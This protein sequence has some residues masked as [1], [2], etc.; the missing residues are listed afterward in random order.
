MSEEIPIANEVVASEAGSSM[1]PGS[2]STVH[3]HVGAVGK[4]N[5]ADFQNSV[6]ALRELAVVNGTENGLSDLTLSISSEP[7]FVRTRAWMLDAV[8]SGD[9]YHL[10]DLD[11]QIDGALLSRL[12]EAECATLKFD[13]RSRRAP[14]VRIAEYQL[15]VE[16][17][18]RNQWGGIGQLPEMIAAFVQPN[19]PAV[20]RLLRSAAQALQQAGLDSAITG[21]GAGPKH[22]WELGSG[23]WTALQQRRLSY[24]LPPAS[25]EATGQKIRGASQVLDA[26]IATCLDLTLIFAACLEQAHL[27]PLLIFTRG[28]AFVGYWL[29]EE[30]FS[31]PVVDDI[32]ALR[33]RLKL[34]E[35]VVFE[36]TLVTQDRPVPFSQAID[37]GARRLSEVDQDQFELA[38]DLKRARMSRIKPLAQA[39]ATSAPDLGAEEPVAIAAGPE[40]APELPEDLTDSFP[41]PPIEPKDRLTQ[42][43][44][45]LLDLSLRNALLN[46]KASKRS[47]QLDAA[48]PALEDALADGQTIKLLTSPFLMEGNDPRSQQLHEARSLED[49]RREHASDALERREVFIRLE[50]EELEGRLV[51]LYRAARTALQEGGANTLF[52]AL[53]FLTWVRPDRPDM[54]VKA[55]LILLPVT[56]ERKSARSGFTI[57]AHEDE[58]RFNPTLVEMLNQDFELDLGIPLGDLPRDESGLDV[59]GIWKRVRLAIKDVNGWEINEDVVLSM[60]SFAK[61]LM[62][63]DLVDR[64]ADLRQ[65]PVVRHLIDTPRE[66][67]RS[68][69]DFPEARSLDSDYPPQQVFSPL[70]ADSSQLS[71]VMAASKGK[72]FVLIGPPGTGKSQTI[73]NLIAQCLAENKRVLFVAEK[74]AALDVVHRRLREVG[75]SEFCLE[76][77]SSKTRKLD[78]LRQLHDAWESTGNI[79][80]ESWVAKADQLR[81]VRDQLSSYV[82]RLHARHT[83]GLTIF[84][85]IGTVVSG[86]SLPELDLSW[87]SSKAHDAQ[88]LGGMRE[89]AGRLSVNAS[90]VG[91]ANLASGPLSQI[92]A[93]DWSVR[94]Q[95]ELVRSA[96]S[97]RE[98]SQHLAESAN[99]LC[100]QLRMSWPPLNKASRMSLGIIAKSLPLAA[101]H[102]WSFFAL[103]QGAEHSA[104]LKAGTELLVDHRNLS[105]QMTAPW[106]LEVQ[107]RLQSA[108]SLLVSRRRI[109]ATLGS[110]LPVA[111]AELLDQG[112]KAL[113]E[114]NELLRGLSVKYGPGINGINVSLLLR[115]WVKA[116]RA[117]WPI[118]WIGR[119]KVRAQLDAVIEG[120][121]EPRIPDDLAALVRIKSL[122]IEL[123]QID[124]GASEVGYWNGAKTKVDNARSASKANIALHAVRSGKSFSLEGVGAASSGHCG[125]RWAAEVGRLGELRQHDQRIADASELSAVSDGLWRGAETDSEALE[126][127]MAFELERRGLLKSGAPTGDHASIAKGRCGV[128]LQQDLIRLQSRV[129]IEQRLRALSD[130][131]THCHDVWRGL[132]TD[133]DKVTQARRFH[134]LL[135]S[136]LSGLPSAIAIEVRQALR[137]TLRDRSRE[138]KNDAGIGRSCGQLVSRLSELNSAVEAFSTLAV[139]PEDCRRATADLSPM[140]LVN[141]AEQVHAH[142]QELHAW[143]GWRSAEA[144]ANAVGLEKLTKSLVDGR[145]APADCARAFEVGYARWW[146][147]ETVDEDEVIKRFV[148][149]E[150]ERR[151]DTFRALD[152]EFTK[153]TRQW[154]RAKLCADLPG[155]DSPLRSAEWGALRREITKKRMHKPLRQLLQEIPSV[156][157]RLTPCLLMSPL[158]IAQ[159]LSASANNFDLVVFDEASQI[160]V[161]DAI[162]AMA[163]GKQVVMVGDPKQLPPTNFFDRAESS[164][165][166]AADVEGDLESILDECIGASLPMRNLSWHYRSKHESLIAFSN[167]RYYGGSLVTFPSP[168]TEDRA[169]SF[170]FVDG[171][172]EKGGARIN[173]PE[174]RA[175]VKDLVGRLKQ[176]KFRESRLTIGVVTFN[177]EQ[178]R[179]IEDLLDEERRRDPSLESYFSEEELEPVFVKNL[180]S[181]QGD[182]RDIMYFSITYGPD[183]TG[184]IAMNFGPLNRDG[185]ERRLNVA[186]TRARHEL[187]VFSSIRGDQIDL[188]RTKAAGVLDLKH[189]LEFAERGS[190]A[191]AEANLGSR[192]DIES[193]FEG[194]VAAA[195]A[196]KGWR[197]DTQIGSSSFRVDLGVVHPDLPGRYLAGIECDG[198]TYHRSATARDRD[199]LREQ[200]L[201][202]LGWKIIRIWSTDWWVN[203]G[204][205]LERVH[206]QLSSLLDQARSDAQARSV[207]DSMSGTLSP[208][209]DFE[210]EA[211]SAST[212]YAGRPLGDLLDAG[213]IEQAEGVEPTEK[214][215]HLPL[216]GP[217]LKASRPADAVPLDAV[218]AAN[219]YESN[220]DPVLQAMIKHVV[221]AE[222]PIL[223]AVLARRIAR[224]HGFQRT[225][226][227]IQERVD[228]LAKRLLRV[229]KESAGLFYWPDDCPPGAPVEFRSPAD[230]QSARGVEEICDQELIALARLVVRSGQ[231]GEAALVA[232][233]REIGLLRLRAASRVPLEAA[234]RIAA[235]G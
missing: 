215:T 118:S 125:D 112:I 223:D 208:P 114:R 169:V 234:L 199:K 181:V 33:K 134:A 12:T 176:P 163:R 194:A 142:H 216:N 67:Y 24:S 187:R 140:E 167:H 81:R 207:E 172:Y 48:A 126:S 38:V 218:S 8:G 62:W 28:H 5:L 71:A 101:G 225:G 11:L 75:L 132:E 136:G 26:G 188:S 120:T 97:L 211:A 217:T 186:I 232:M 224:A 183:L 143:C 195:L 22:A 107:E 110:P 153:I 52:V 178:Q 49:L 31:T 147:A 84:Q 203:P 4:L 18:P 73:A 214:G 23:L 165:G 86:Q 60:F 133:I 221:A 42:W 184:A 139:Q 174:A 98:A 212:E 27:N 168:V 177:A 36:T 37:H 158:S 93:R 44:R 202:G 34:Q 213:R 35:L 111:S 156:V 74:I 171:Q 173:K 15:T 137:E 162:G 113:D 77:H 92:Y 72:D 146:V 182:E 209:F 47:L 105:S 51:E 117:I 157:L 90:A 61:Y 129:A 46:F 59:P 150:H 29:K 70:P 170:H 204:G 3:I 205:T 56:L 20:D 41:L 115:E 40:R 94:W 191:L 219:F 164:E 55:P 235:Q 161:W 210:A 50:K 144:D 230:A 180:E 128:R 109:H 160:P 206:A 57:R 43:Q 9:T 6:P 138:L 16:L 148:S 229:T 231:S 220:Y 63:K 228:E 192:G 103:P 39:E 65:S 123:S 193:P 233:A 119:R 58:V 151:I 116:E 155:F 87:G 227:R 102:D 85:A 14:E 30:Q 10:K 200:V 106:S 99:I 130:L 198:A 141:I 45:K 149:A 19:D 21:Y 25:F 222:G 80:K 189:F 95:Q 69:V 145:T 166:D 196:T 91:A 76:L 201:R 89:I 135:Q 78:V 68:A 7:A 175:L 154:I 104:M 190:R 96:H 122:E 13:L 197:I 152:E 131:D 108:H 226:G 159:Y 82:T 121:G 127:A 32:T 2:S 64:T 124:L 88:A 185:G 66:P 179:L 79:D 100:E 1:N 53:G 17:L 83:N 54:R